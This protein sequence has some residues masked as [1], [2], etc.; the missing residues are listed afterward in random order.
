M[1]YYQHDANRHEFL[2]TFESDGTPYDLYFGRDFGEVVAR[3]GNG[4][5][6][7]A[8]TSLRMATFRE[9]GCPLREAVGRVLRKY[10]N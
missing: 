4:P 3:F 6:A 2:G 8:A 5:E 10:G 9:K 7:Y 1:K